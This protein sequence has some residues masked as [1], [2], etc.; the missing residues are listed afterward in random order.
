MAKALKVIGKMRKQ[1]LVDNLV[2]KHK[3]IKPLEP[4]DVAQLKKTIPKRYKKYREASKL[5]IEHTDNMLKRFSINPKLRNAEFVFL[6]RDA[7]PYMH[8]AREL[9]SK[10][11]FRKE[12]FKPAKI[13]DKAETQISNYL[14][15]LDYHESQLIS[16]MSNGEE[17]RQISK[18]LPNTSELR[19]LKTI[20]ARELDLTKPIVVIDSGIQGTAVK[21][22]Q[23]LLKSLNSNIQTHSSLFFTSLFSKDHVDLPITVPSY[24]ANLKD[25]ENTPKFQGKLLKTE[26]QKQKIK[27]KRQDHSSPD[28]RFYGGFSDPLNSEIFMIALRNTLFRYKKEKGIK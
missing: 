9:C 2:R 15:K 13:T 12:Q 27:L 3:K 16:I 20:I 8:I 17:I 23:I 14:K 26:N 21:K 4:L 1:S 19:N 7:L 18:R 24:F 11:G 22:Y 5:L 10:Y 28:S 25:I 6:D